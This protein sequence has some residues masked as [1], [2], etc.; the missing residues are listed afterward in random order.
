MYMYSIIERQ[1]CETKPDR[2]KGRKRQFHSL[3]GRLSQ[4]P[5]EH[6]DKKKK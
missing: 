3:N 4:Q 5:I 2:I 6:P 1:I